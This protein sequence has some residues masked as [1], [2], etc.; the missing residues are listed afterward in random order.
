MLNWYKVG[1]LLALII[2]AVVLNSWI[3]ATI[4]IAGVILYLF[5]KFFD[6]LYPV[7]IPEPTAKELAQRQEVFEKEVKAELNRIAAMSN[8]KNVIGMR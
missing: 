8:I 5:D 4:A 6:R 2:A 3:S 7:G 1:I